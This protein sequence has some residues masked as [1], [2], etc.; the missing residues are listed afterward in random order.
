MPI[1][2]RDGITLAP[3]LAGSK[4]AV[5]GDAIIRVMLHGLTGPINGKTYEAQMVTMATNDDQWI[6]DVTSYIRKA[7]GNNGKFVDKKD[8]AKLR[9]DLAKRTA[10]WTIEETSQLLPANAH[11]PQGLEA[12]LKPQRQGVAQSYRRRHHHALGHA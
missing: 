7:F 10:P 8:V 4:T 9:K 6:A 1:A 2:G 3:P 11:Q 5:Q 12:H